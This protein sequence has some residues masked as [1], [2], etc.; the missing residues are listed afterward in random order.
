MK[1]TNSLRVIAAAAVILAGVCSQVLSQSFIAVDKGK[2]VAT[3]VVGSKPEASELHAARELQKYFQI[4]TGA[5]LPISSADD[6]ALKE[7]VG[8]ILIGRAETNE[9]IRALG[10]KGLIRLSADYPGMDGFIVKTVKDA[11]VSYL[12][13]GGST[14]IGSLY[15]VYALLEDFCGVGFFEDGDRVPQK[16]TLDFQDIN[17]A[18]KPYFPIRQYLQGCALWYT[19]YY[20]TFDR[21]QQELDWMAKRRYNILVMSGSIGSEVIWYKVF[22]DLGIETTPPTAWNRYQADIRKKVLDYARRIGMEIVTAGGEARVPRAFINAYPDSDYITTAVTVSA[23]GIVPG[24]P[25]F[26]KLLVAGMREYNRFYGPSYIYN[27]DPYA[28]MRPGSTHA[29]QQR[30]KMNYAR[31]V[32]KAIKQVDPQGRWFA[33][34]W[35]FRD[36]EY[37]PS[38]DVKAFL[39]IIPSDM[40]YLSDPIAEIKPLYKKD[41]YF[42]GKD[43]VF[44]VL[45]TLGKKKGLYGDVAGLIE[46]VRQVVADPK[47]NNCKGIY[48]NP[49]SICHNILYFDLAGELAWNPNRV[50]LEKFLKDYALRRYGRESA[51][52]MVRV[53]NKLVETAYGPGTRQGGANEAF[54]QLRLGKIDTDDMDAILKRTF[55]I[56]SLRQAL[57][58]MLK[59][60]DRQK[61]N[62]LYE[63]DLVDIMRQYLTERFNHHL[64][65]LYLAFE[66]GDRDS[67]E[68]E[69]G[70]VFHCLDGIEKVL[71]TRRDYRLT[72]L[73]EDVKKLPCADDIPPQFLEN[74][75]ASSDPD[76][77]KGID[78]EGVVK[79][80]FVYLDDYA[81]TDYYELIKGYYRKRVEAYVDYLREKMAANSRD[82]TSEQL[83]PIYDRLRDRWM[84]EP[85]TAPAMYRPTAAEAVE[86]VLQETEN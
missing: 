36:E 39:D 32:V 48:T 53:L 1:I 38:R 35:A 58:I 24:D 45:H 34:G 74:M 72:S 14:P 50:A 60:R 54:Y 56:P 68:A 19:C 76:I 51:D 71:S 83:K 70:I 61:N 78:V 63:N 27:Y 23:T 55:F 25:M 44:G 49:E 15:A 41:D 9:M 16:K 6:P 4:M 17:L 5:I 10:S 81:R 18:E 33:S 37:W 62:K 21:W 22:K 46:S 82:I 85:L 67:F 77:A 75:L 73:V 84:R 7:A 86:A 52:N 47:A 26:T 8:L 43:W 80:E 2:A 28:E 12:I 3:I 30:I 69:A 40:F 79:S 42:F 64:A 31:S 66:K 20:W 59:E 13:C 11:N 29:Q 65:K 57:E